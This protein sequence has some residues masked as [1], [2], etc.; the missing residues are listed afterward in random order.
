[1]GQEYV[2]GVEVATVTFSNADVVAAIRT[3]RKLRHA[4]VCVG[5]D[6]NVVRFIALP[7][8]SE[9]LS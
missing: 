9:A 6:T 8:P 4:V 5:D 1:M 7:H 2:H 3:A